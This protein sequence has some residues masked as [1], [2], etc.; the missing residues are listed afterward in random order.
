MRRKEATNYRV[1]L[2]SSHSAKRDKEGFDEYLELRYPLAVY[3]EW[4]LRSKSNV[5]MIR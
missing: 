4:P 5:G 3:F 1:P 2:K